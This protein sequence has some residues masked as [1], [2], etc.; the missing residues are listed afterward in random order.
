MIASSSGKT[1][2]RL[3]R[4]KIKRAVKTVLPKG[5]E[6]ALH[7]ADASIDNLKIVRVVT[8][9]WK[10]LRPWRRIGKVRPA[11]ENELTPAERDAILRISVLTPE[12]YRELVLD[13]PVRAANAGRV[14]PLA[15]RRRKRPAKTKRALAK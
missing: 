1:G 14:K 2:A 4:M 3:S 15:A 12:E 6:F 7:I 9:A 5:K 10:T 13:S 11:I 8:P